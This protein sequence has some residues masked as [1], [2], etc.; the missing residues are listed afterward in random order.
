MKITEVKISGK[1]YP[2]AFNMRA[3]DA[4]CKH[5]GI[6]HLGGL[7]QKLS[8]AGASSDGSGFAFSLEELAALLSVTA[9]KGFRKNKS[10][11]RVSVDDA[12]DLLD[13]APGLAIQLIEG[14]VG[15]IQSITGSAEPEPAGEAQ[16]R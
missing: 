2:L 16:S 1:L 14:L 15:S 6:P 12:F 13:E 9:N 7:F 11:E 10:E 3:L 4:F 5:C 8:Q